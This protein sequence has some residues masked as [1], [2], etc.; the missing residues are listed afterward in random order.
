M[1]KDVLLTTGRLQVRFFW[2]H[3]R[4]AH[5]LSL[6][7]GEWTVPLLQSLEGSADDAWPPSPP[8]QSLHVESR[9]DMQVALAVGMAG[10]S[11]WSASVEVNSDGLRFDIACRVRGEPR[12]LGSCYR[13][14]P[15]VTCES[16]D[17][18]IQFLT[19]AGNCTLAGQEI[20]GHFAAM[21][22][23]SNQVA[24]VVSRPTQPTPSARWCYVIGV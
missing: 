8:L 16:H 13:I 24:L 15:D 12:A 3:D 21:Q 7:D 2:Q 18:G 6:S 19:K 4:F 9:G 10:A 22:A 11:H 14:M 20:D 5:E 17:A 23:A 1:Q